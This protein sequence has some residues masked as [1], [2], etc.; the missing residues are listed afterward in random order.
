MTTFEVIQ[1]VGIWLFVFGAIVGAIGWLL[2]DLLDLSSYV[3]DAFLIT[4]RVVLPVGAALAV[5]GMIAT[6]A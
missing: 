3:P 1:W 6:Y 5:V 2:C 4:A